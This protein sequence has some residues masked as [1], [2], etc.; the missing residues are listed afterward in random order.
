[1]NDVIYITGHKNPDTDSICSALSYAELKKKLGTVNAKAVRLGSVSKETQY[2]LD[3]FKVEAPELVESMKAQ[4]S[5]LKYDDA[6]TIKP[7]QSIKN[8]WER[9]NKSKG[10]TLAVIDEEGKLIG[11]ASQSTVTSTYMDVW[12]SEVIKKSGVKIENIIDTLNAKAL[13][14]S[15]DELRGKIVVA[16]MHPDSADSFINEGDIVICGN[17]KDTEEL[18]IRKKA[19]LMI[20]TG[21]HEVD[22]DTLEKAKAINCSIISTPYDTFTTSRLLPQSVPVKYIMSKE[23]LVSFKVDDY[24]DDVKDIMLNTRFRSYPVL[25]SNGIVVGSLSRYHL[26]SPSKKKIILVDHNEKSQSVNGLEDAELLEIID[27]H[28]IADIQTSGPIYFR[29]QPVGCTATIVANMYF[30]NGLEPSKEIAGLLC[31]AIISDTLLFKSPTATKADK[32]VVDR[33]AKV[34]GI[35]PEKYAKEMFRAGSSLSGKTA[36]EI[37][38]QDFKEF[39]LG[40]LKLGVSQISTVDLEGLKPLKP[41]ILT[42]MNNMVKNEKYDLLILMLTDI[43]DEGSE[44]IVIGE[45]KDL[46]EKAFNVSI[47]G[48]T[49]Y[50]PGI[51]SRKK[52]VIPPL[53]AA[54][55]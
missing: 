12:D 40:S 14:L 13:Y 23:N 37:F 50:V 41:D 27:H 52:Q 22:N 53:Q 33:L 9:I 24:V 4:V 48:D 35:E 39:G 20:I 2:A 49:V 38:N 17:R 43:L 6:E 21:G 5:D 25:D 44:L 55:K 1:M 16:A 11:I 45:R 36:E 19:A 54:V 32:V 42:L 3:Y 7:D 51:L 26:I 18:V 46:A 31:S 47:P 15:K 34:A 30:E 29:N 10:K 28:R 8:A